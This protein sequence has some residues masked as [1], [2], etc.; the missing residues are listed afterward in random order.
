MLQAWFKSLITSSAGADGWFCIKSALNQR[1]SSV[2]N[3]RCMPNWSCFRQLRGLTCIIVLSVISVSTYTHLFVWCCL[4][5]EPWWFFFIRGI[6][7]GCQAQVPLR[8]RLTVC[9]SLLPRKTSLNSLCRSAV[10]FRT[11]SACNCSRAY[12][13]VGNVFF[14]LAAAF[15]FTCFLK[16]S[17]WFK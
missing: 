3:H 8:K 5:G 2:L 12:L 14:S 13:Q 7:W 16:F 15:I 11:F 9:K 4:R 1:H 10:W 17:H 6:F